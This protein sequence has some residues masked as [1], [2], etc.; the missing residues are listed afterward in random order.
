MKI[1]IDDLDK[2]MFESYFINW[3]NQKSLARIK[4]VHENYFTIEKIR[5]I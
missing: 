2:S 4:S 3:T 5:T 1:K